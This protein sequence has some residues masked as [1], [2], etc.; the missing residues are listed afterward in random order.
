LAIHLIFYK[1]DQWTLDG[2]NFNFCDS[3]KPTIIISGGSGGLIKS[4]YLLAKKYSA[5]LIIDYRDPWNFGYQLLETKSYIH[6]FKKRFTFSNEL[7]FLEFASHIT[8]VSDTLKSY[9]P[10]KFQHKI[11]VIENG[12]NFEINDNQYKFEFKSFNIT[13]TGTLY[14]DQLNDESFFIALRDFIKENHISSKHLRLQFIGSSNNKNLIQLIKNYNL[15]NYTKVT[16]RF[17]LMELKEVLQESWLF[18]HLKYGNRSGIITS[19]NADYLFFNKPI[20]LPNTDNGDIAESI[21]RNKAG[22]VCKG[23]SNE[24]KKVLDIEYQKYINGIDP[25]FSKT[26]DLSL[27]R[28]EIAKKLNQII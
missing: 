15:D 21:L 11:T 27:T 19:K 20:L 13:Y 28:T 22:Y 23:D 4:S 24:I 26:P 14:D 5:K 9:F 10:F 7:K 17:N 8:T 16:R 18:L 12:S 3:L 6:Y 25:R 1:S 2:S